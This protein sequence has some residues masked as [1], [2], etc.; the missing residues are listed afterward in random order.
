M[1]LCLLTGCTEVLNEDE[2]E[3]AN[4]KANEDAN[5]KATEDANANENEDEDEDETAPDDGWDDVT[6]PSTLPPSPLAH[7][8]MVAQSTLRS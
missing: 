2:H 5:A 8:V 1:L 3:D 7:S 4:A 6:G